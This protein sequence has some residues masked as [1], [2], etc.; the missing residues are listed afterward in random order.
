ML[1]LILNE[2][3]DIIHYA[4]HGTFDPQ[5]PNKSGWVFGNNI[6]LSAREIFRVRQVPQLV[7][8]NACFSAV[9]R[10]G[11]AGAPDESNRQLAG[12]A[13]AFFERGVQNYLGSGWPVGDEEALSF[14]SAFYQEVLDGEC[15]SVA[16]AAARTKIMHLG[17]T[18]GAYQHY[19]QPEARL[20][21]LPGK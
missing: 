12:L 14:A 19:G 20:V 8:S 13:E 7:F 11:Q 5:N 21:C 2:E 18:W 6:I 4:G 17:T 9:V 3:F 1:A 16:I 10:S 15:L